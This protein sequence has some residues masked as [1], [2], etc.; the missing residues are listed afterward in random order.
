[1]SSLSLEE[2]ILL[3]QKSFFLFLPLGKENENVPY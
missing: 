2:Q 3:K 1:M